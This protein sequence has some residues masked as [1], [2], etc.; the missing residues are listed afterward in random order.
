MSIND[1][2][3]KIGYLLKQFVAIYP[4]GNTVP[5]SFDIM[6]SFALLANLPKVCEF[7]QQATFYLN[8]H[9]KQNVAKQKEQP[10]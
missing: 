2:F 6:N 5:I 7:P 8:R 3:L 1:T 10:F 4:C 9:K